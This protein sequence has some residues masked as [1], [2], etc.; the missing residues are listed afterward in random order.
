MQ[1]TPLDYLK[2]TDMRSI[3]IAF[4]VLIGCNIQM[5]LAVDTSTISSPQLV[6]DYQP[7]PTLHTVFPFDAS[8]DAQ[9]LRAAMEGIGTNEDEIIKILTR[10]TEAQ[11]FLIEQS[12]KIQFQRELMADLKDELTGNLES[13]IVGLLEG[14]TTFLAHRLHHAVKGILTDNEAIT[15]ILCPRTNNEISHILDVYRQRYEKSF[16]EEIGID[17]SSHYRRLILAL[18]NG[19]RRERDPLNENQARLDADVLY[20]AGAGMTGTDED[21]FNAILTHRNARQ[22]RIIFKEYAKKA[23]RSIEEAIRSETS[24]S[25]RAALLA[26]VE[27]AQN[28]AVYFAKRLNEAMEGIGTNEK[29]LIRTIVSRAEIDL[30]NI[31]LQYERLFDRTMKYLVTSEMPY[32]H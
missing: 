1:L 14:P 12:Y 7:V 2:H 6:P 24:G 22:L 32:F 17:T 21:T 4:T 16:N 9:A 23:G 28:R 3:T 19:A 15:D 13:V 5:L 30:G 29:V 18:V 8:A 27:S 10:R 26:I 11:R 31:K 20:N 25:M